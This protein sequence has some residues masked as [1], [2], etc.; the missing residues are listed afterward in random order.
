VNPNYLR[1]DFSHFSKVTDEQI[2]QVE[3]F[4]NQRIQEQLPLIER[5]TIPI[6]QALDEGAMALFGEKYGDNVRAIKFGDSMELCGGIHVENT[7]NIWH[8]KI[9]S[10]GAVAAGIRRIEAITGDAVKDYF[11]KQEN[12]LAE[13]KETLKNPQDTIKAVVS[14]QDENAKLKKQVEHLLK[15]KIDGLKNNLITEFQEIN[16]IN[17]LSKQVDLSMTAAKDLA[18]AIGSSQANSFVFLASIEDG[19]PNIHCYI[20]KE[21][22]TEKGLNAGNIIRELGKLIDGNGGG[23]PFFA[24]GKGKNASRI[25]EALEKVIDFV[26]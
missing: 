7:A 24:S 21:L 25:K 6:Q 20:S 2:K 16:G 5:R 19:M 18:M 1:F 15:D 26:K 13:I 3:D 11:A 4:V 23:Q 9:I 10:E 8:F 14:L 12:T 17:F 22:V